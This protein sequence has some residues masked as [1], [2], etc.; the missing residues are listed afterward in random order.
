[1][2]GEMKQEITKQ[3][4][5]TFRGETK[6]AQAETKQEITKQYQATLRE[7]I[8]RTQSETKREITKRVKLQ[9]ENVHNHIGLVPFST[10]MTNFQQKKLLNVSWYSP[11]FYTH[12]CG[13]KM[14]LRVDANGSHYGMNSHISV[15]VYMMKG[16]YDDRLNWP[17]RG[18]I[19]IQMLSQAGDEE[20]ST[21]ILDVTA[22]DDEFGSRVLVRER[23][24]SGLG[25]F[26]FI[27]HQQLNPKFLKDNCLRL[28]VPEVNIA[29]I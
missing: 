18:D 3:H 4:Q 7:E 10:T 25:I 23:A 27:P 20:R 8:K 11:S 6:R 17:F 29:S 12:P 2:K 13:Y 9:F 21:R 5:T 14:C 26:Q 19:T 24:E 1:M 16:D 15:F 22:D 28:C